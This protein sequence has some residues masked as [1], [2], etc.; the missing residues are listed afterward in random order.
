[1]SIDQAAKP[2]YQLILLTSAFPD[3]V[4]KQKKKALVCYA[5]RKTMSETVK[6]WLTGRS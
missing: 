6:R 4:V 3:P 5:T 1:M 2:V